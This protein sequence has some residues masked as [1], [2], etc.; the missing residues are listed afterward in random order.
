MK[1]YNIVIH[2]LREF[3]DK[4]NFIE[5]FTQ[6]KLGILTV[7]DD[8]KAM[9]TFNYGGYVWPLPQSNI[10]WLEHELLTNQDL[11]GI[12]SIC[13]MY[14]NDPDY[15]KKNI[16]NVFEAD[17][18]TPKFEFVTFGQYSDIIATIVNLLRELGFLEKYV[19]TN[20]NHIA[21]RRGSKELTIDDLAP[22]KQVTFV[23]Y[24]PIKKWGMKYTTKVYIQ[25]KEILVLSEHLTE[26][27]ELLETF[28]TLDDG[29]LSN[30]LY[31]QFSKE[32]VDDEL[33][34]FINTRG[35]PTVSCSIHIPN[36]MNVMHDL[37][38]LFN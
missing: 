7:C 13:T 31:A 17:I 19:F 36:L 1:R 32:R 11:T 33:F 34:K 6:N 15:T 22:S 35:K 26:S 29:H 3:C 10:I 14:K 27:N 24:I 5:L 9:C 12:Y 2:R 20:Y 37:D 18:V 21:K 25:Q 4:L 28:L 16:E 8:P 38:M 23:E 30:Y